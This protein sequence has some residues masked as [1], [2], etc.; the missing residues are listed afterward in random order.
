MIKLRCRR[1]HLA[2]VIA[3]FAS[4]FMTPI[5]LATSLEGIFSSR[6]GNDVRWNFDE[7]KTWATLRIYSP[8]GVLGS[9]LMNADPYD[10]MTNDL[11]ITKINGIEQPQ[12]G[13]YKTGKIIGEWWEI[14]GNHTPDNPQYNF[15]T[16]NLDERGN[17]DDVVI[18]LAFKHRVPIHAE[19][20]GAGNVL[21]QGMSPWL[22]APDLVADESGDTKKHGE[23]KDILEKHKISG[24]LRSSE[25]PGSNEY[26][27]WEYN[28]KAVHVV[29]IPPAV[30]LFGSGMLMLSFF[31]SKRCRGRIA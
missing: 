30:L 16:V 6:A 15:P 27:A 8:T 9:E 12:D 26:V 17:S 10:A 24:T 28:G 4:I 7:G 18:S 14:V 29:P 22:K 31:S 1:S 19:D 13:E 5:V 23:H 3:F 2:L 25:L 20:G 11:L 21:G